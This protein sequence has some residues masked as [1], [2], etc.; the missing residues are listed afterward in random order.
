MQRSMNSTL[1]VLCCFCF[2]VVAIAFVV[3]FAVVVVKIT[4]ISNYFCMT[5]LV[6]S[7]FD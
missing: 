5:F 4:L 1:A 2:F 7:R 6:Y 3:M